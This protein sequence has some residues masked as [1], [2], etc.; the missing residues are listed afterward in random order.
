MES[1]LEVFAEQVGGHSCIFRNTQGR[2]YKPASSHE[3]E[4]YR[5]PPVALVNHIPR[6]FGS[7]AINCSS[8]KSKK[9][10][11]ITEQLSKLPDKKRA[12][13]M[14]E[15]YNKRYQPL[16]QNVTNTEYGVFEDLTAGMKN[17]CVLDLK[18]GSRPYNPSKFQHQIDKFKRS[19]S[20]TLHFRMNGAKVF[21]P[22]LG[23]AEFI[24]KHVGRQMSVEDIKSLFEWFLIDGNRTYFSVISKLIAKLQKIQEGVRRSQGCFFYSSSL[25]V[26]YDPEVLEEAVPR[27]CVK[28]IDF[29]RVDH[30]PSRTETD[31][32]IMLA[33]RNIESFLREIANSYSVNTI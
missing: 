8:S 1:E 7:I 22:S 9:L 15:L 24:S 33:L 19:T 18:L 5:H 12:Q 4:F 27:V 6:F 28:L 17:P 2:L 10:V 30:E 26:V 13:W 23:Q 3:L 20:S 11:A 14:C 32:D 29:D 16:P 31:T 21:K 25:L